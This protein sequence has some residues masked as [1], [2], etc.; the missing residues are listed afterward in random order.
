LA[1]IPRG[2]TPIE[3]ANEKY[4]EGLEIAQ[5]DVLLFL[6]HLPGERPDEYAWYGED[7]NNDDIEWFYGEKYA[8]NGMDIAEEIDIEYEEY[9]S[10]EG[11]NFFEF[12]KELLW[13]SLD[14]K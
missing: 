10:Y 2:E 8:N 4:L 9:D 5:F 1:D 12:V 11:E 7:D 3:I 14:L 6:Y 13:H